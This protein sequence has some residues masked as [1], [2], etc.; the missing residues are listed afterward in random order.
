MP[1]IV[2]IHY[3]RDI[4][5]LAVLCHEMRRE[6]VFRSSVTADLVLKH[7][8]AIPVIARVVVFV[9]LVVVLVVLVVLV[10]Y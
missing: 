1:G 3:F 4:R 6:I 2:D 8:K 9:V 7:L 5:D 10:V